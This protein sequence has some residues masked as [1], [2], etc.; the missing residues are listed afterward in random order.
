MRQG[1]NSRS[2]LLEHGTQLMLRSGYAG[3][4]LVEL[5]GA[6]RVPKGSF[7]NH[8][9][10]KEEFGIALVRRYYDRH[11]RLLADLIAQ[12]GRSPLE[13]VR[14]YF[15]D[16][17]RDTVGARPQAR[18]CLM[19]MFALEMSGCSEPLREAVSDTFS[20]WQ[21]RVAELLRQAQIAGELDPAQDPQPLAAML[22]EGWEGALMRA[23]VSHDLEGL[24]TFIELGLDR[25]LA[26]GS[27]RAG[28]E[29]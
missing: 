6:A 18:G 25:L 16:A 1:D 5:L 19:A 21:A 26:P 9:A 27:A 24:R 2:A 23:R 4:G 11:D 12:T 15:E 29:R 13:R 28:Q 8:F 14:S 3:T 20:R 7:Y 17:L 10:S 22:L